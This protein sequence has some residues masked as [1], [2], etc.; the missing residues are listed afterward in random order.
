MPFVAFYNLRCTLKR[1]LDFFASVKLAMFLFIM[2]A[3]GSSIGT[4]VQQN[5]SGS[6]AVFWL[7]DKLGMTHEQVYN[8]LVKA[9]I[10]DLYSSWWFITL[11]VLFGL[12]LTVCTFYRLSHV[13]RQLKTPVTVN[14][15]IFDNSSNSVTFEA[16]DDAE[17]K[18]RSFLKNYSTVEE[19]DGKTLY[20]AAEK[21]R[22]SRSGVYITHLGIMVILIAAL[23]GIIFGFK[24]NLGVIEGQSDDVVVFADGKT[25]PLPFAVRLDNFD[26]KYYKDSVK[27]ELYRSDITII[28]NKKETQAQ[29]L[30]NS[31]VSYKGYRLFQTNFGFYANKDLS[32]IMNTGKKGQVKQIAAS[33]GKKF[34]VPGTEISAEVVDFAPSLGQDE[35]GRLVNFNT[36]MMNPAV[37][38]E[39]FDENEVSL[40]TKWVFNAYPESGLFNDVSIQFEDVRGAQY[41][42]LSVTYDPAEYIVYVG[43][44]ILGLGVVI[45]FYFRHERIWVRITETEGKTVVSAC[46][47]RSKFK[48][49]VPE[50][51]EKLK[52]STL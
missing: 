39:V 28:D 17:A 16:D 47:D 38:I 35:K 5:D 11:L 33:F 34:T 26:V 3:L 8:F 48:S 37:L 20:L 10:A 15:N 13:Y 44:F 30:V 49:S 25:K 18:V 46:A 19:T 40:G 43:F 12:N 29:I 32:F 22:F 50:L 1:I 41:S 52:N 6:K 24:G 14:R 2:I 27:A 23:A 45:A 51:L 36:L 7:S 21:G 42:V 9:G 31:P 4:F